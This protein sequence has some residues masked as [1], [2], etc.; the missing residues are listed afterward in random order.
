LYGAWLQK[1]CFSDSIS[2]KTTN[3]KAQVEQLIEGSLA[4]QI[5]IE[6]QC[7]ENQL[8][9]INLVRPITIAKTALQNQGL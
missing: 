5:Q 1:S 8:Y 4:A 7:Y 6:L 9:S 3:K 2:L